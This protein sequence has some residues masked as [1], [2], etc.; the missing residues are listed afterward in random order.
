M[1]CWDVNGQKI[2]SGSCEPTPS[3]TPKP[4]KAPTAVPTPAPT[5]KAHWAVRMSCEDAH[6][7]RLDPKNCMKIRNRHSVQGQLLD[8]VPVGGVTTLYYYV[9]F[10][11][12]LD[13]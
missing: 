11:S 10:Y 3:P 13:F 6:G 2:H 1:G 9:L 8:V 7:N 12:L 4:T 5:V